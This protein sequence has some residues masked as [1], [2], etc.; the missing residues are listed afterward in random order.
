[1]TG[2]KK[3]MRGNTLILILTVLLF[4]FG[5]LGGNNISETEPA[6]TVEMTNQLTF[7][8]DTVTIEKGETVLW[9]NTSLLVHSVTADHDKK[10]EPESVA[11]PEGAEPFDSGLMDPEEEFS[12]TFTV[13]G[14]YTYFCIPHEAAMRGVVIVE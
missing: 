11:L 7:K 10:T 3:L 4:L 8:P 6:V 5:L 9:K 2:I 12:H 13:K 14:T 1:M